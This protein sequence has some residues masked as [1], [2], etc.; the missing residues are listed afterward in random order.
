MRMWQSGLRLSRDVQ[1][2]VALAL[3]EAW[4]WLDRENFIAFRSGFHSTDDYFVTARH[5]ECTKADIEPERGCATNIE[6]HC[7]RM[8]SYLSSISGSKCNYSQTRPE[9]S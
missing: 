4:S 7:G 5:F 3:M 9:S 6:A 2:R 8:V 1:Y